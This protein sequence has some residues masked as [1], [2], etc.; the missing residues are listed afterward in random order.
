M[1]RRKHDNGSELF[2]TVNIATIHAKYFDTLSFL[3][4]CECDIYEVQDF[5]ISIYY[6]VNIT[7]QLNSQTSRL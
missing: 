3:L 4:H 2:I 1:S 7:F 6:D 5:T